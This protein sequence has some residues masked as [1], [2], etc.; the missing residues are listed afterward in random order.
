MHKICEKIAN[1]EDNNYIDATYFINCERIVDE[2]DDQVA[3]YAGPMCGS[4]GSK[5]KTGVSEDEDCVFLNGDHDVEDY[6]ADE[7][8]YGLKLSHALLKTTYDN[9]DPIN[10]KR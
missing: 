5:I 7:D 10:A 8:G 9:S 2:G 6:L 3:L 4:Q 1:R